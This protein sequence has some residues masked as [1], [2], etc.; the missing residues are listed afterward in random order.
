MRF[1]R[2][3]ADHQLLRDLVVGFGLG[4]QDSHFALARRQIVQLASGGGCS[5]AFVGRLKGKS[6]AS[7]KYV[8]FS[9]KNLK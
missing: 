2:S 1:H 4:D 5:G 6:S 8:P 7:S 3:L 9:C